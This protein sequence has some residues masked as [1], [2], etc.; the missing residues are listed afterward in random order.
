MYSDYLFFDSIDDLYAM[1]DKY[2]DVVISSLRDEDSE[3]PSYYIE[4]IN[5]Q[6]IDN[7]EYELFTDRITANLKIKADRIKRIEMQL[8]CEKIKKKLFN[9]AKCRWKKH[10]RELYGGYMTN[11]T[12]LLN[13]ARNYLMCFQ[14]LKEIYNT[15]LFDSGELGLAFPVRLSCLAISLALQVCW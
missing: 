4:E 2:P 10:I 1:K 14:M 7:Q 8:E 9:I 6:I 11:N 5:F 12:L 15:N 3:N 13:Y